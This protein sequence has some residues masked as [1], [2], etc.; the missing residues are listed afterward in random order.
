MTER[1]RRYKGGLRSVS[2]VVPSGRSTVRG[3]F[4]FCSRTPT[5]RPWKR[6]NFTSLSR[7][8]PDVEDAT[9]TS[10]SSFRNGRWR[11]HRGCLPSKCGAPKIGFARK[12]AGTRNVAV[13]NY[14]RTPV[15]TSPFALFDNE[16][17]STRRFYASH[18]SD[19]LER[20]N[21]RD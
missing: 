13:E 21:F 10:N 18:P 15:L 4:R 6:D 8:R 3:L 7:P 5:E 14:G 20:A 19:R 12:I 2:T 9:K 16:L 1:V 11:R 17:V